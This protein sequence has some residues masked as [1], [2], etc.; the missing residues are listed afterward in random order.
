M[1][2]QQETSSVR[3]RTSKVKW[4][5]SIPL[6][7]ICTVAVVTFSIRADLHSNSWVWFQRSG[8]VLVLFGAVLSYRSIFRMGVQGVGGV[9]VTA[10]RGRVVNVDDSGPIQML[11]VEYDEATLKYLREAQLDKVAGSL[12]VPLLLF[13]TVVWGY[14]DL[15]PRL[16]SWIFGH[17]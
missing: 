15:V 17:G 10:T 11:D 13:G 9:N 6:A 14:G 5:A 16:L 3:A 8:A 2:E 12:G 1:A 4:L 7:L